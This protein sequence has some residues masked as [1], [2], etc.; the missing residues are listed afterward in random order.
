[1]KL[2]FPRPLAGA[3]LLAFAG[4]AGATLDVAGVDASVDACTDFY[5]Y[6]N[7][8]WLAATPIPD[9][10]A[11]WGTFEVIALRNEQLLQKAFEDAL[12]KPL[13]AAG[14]ER[15]V[16][17]HYA[18]GMDAAAIEKAGLAPLEP[19]FT[20]IRAVAS[21]KDI[22]QAIARMH[23]SGMGAGFDFGVQPDARDS[24]R[25][26]AELAQGGLG[27]PDR[28]YYFLEDERST[29]LRE[30]YRKHVARMFELAGD[31]AAAAARNAGTVFA[32]ESELARA[33][34]TAT[35][36]RDVDKTYNKMTLAQL[37]SEAPGLPWR[38]YFAALGAKG[39]ADVNVAQPAFF[40]ALGRLAAERP[41]AEWQTY[42]RWHALH[43]AA[44]KLPPAFE[45]E[46][47]DFYD[48]Q[49]H[50]TQAPAPR[51][52][53][54]M[55]TI[56]GD[57][58]DQ[59]LGMAV[60]RIFVDNA[61]SPA[62]KTR[63]LELI[64]NVKAAL[65]DRLKTV[66]WMTETTR[67]RS[68][69]KLAAMQIKIGY[70]DKWRDYSGADIG[71]YSFVENWMR[72][73]AFD[74][75]RDVNRAGQ[76]VDRTDWLMSPHVVNAYYNARGNEIVFP[77]AILQPPYFDAKADDAVN[78]GGI[79]MV[80]GHEITHGF[81][82]RGRRFDKDGNLRDW[83]TPEDERRYTERAQRIV[84]QY[85]GFEGIEGVKPN[86]TLTLGE[87]ISDVGGMKIAYD[88][89]QRALKARPQGKI[90]GLTPEQR[91]FLAFGQAWR[92]K[93]RLEWERNALLT[94]QH[95]LPRFRV[96][97]PLAHMP[98]FARAFACDPSKTLLS[99]GAGENIW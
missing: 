62:A 75:R 95:S 93:A 70:P 37:S 56:G 48:R 1:M 32:L 49:F 87:N 64:Q 19:H 4:S 50:G 14:P 34:M 80:I 22:A 26:L 43:A 86:G 92:A 58:G 83:W 25:Y 67:Q 77:A 94:G 61:F 9:D 84:Q 85:G 39:I 16:L 89:L 46:N 91:F 13:P 69:E 7:R 11:R 42:L 12:R 20:R 33:S 41:A 44:S 97:G 53:R 66:D 27:M 73:A 74:V 98:E 17:Q 15:M 28:D 24:T 59:G 79:G 6:A 78:Y 68:L 8:K 60:G 3:L 76:P 51:H 54:V 47:F 10:R 36:R 71:P 31:D 5:Q 81:D 63:A 82:N 30:G 38:D 55:R 40:K 57:F 99:A 2:A 88:A 29:K 90:D 52:R 96:R 21:P 18:S 45:S 65:G 72:S 23:A 35:E